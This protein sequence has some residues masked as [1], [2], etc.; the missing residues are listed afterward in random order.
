MSSFSTGKPLRK[1]SEA[2]ELL[3]SCSTPPHSDD[4]ARKSPNPTHSPSGREFRVQSTETIGTI[5]LFHVWSKSW[6]PWQRAG[7]GLLRGKRI[8]KIT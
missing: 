2:A 5:N 3:L 1:C 8:L 7:T 6:F 4:G